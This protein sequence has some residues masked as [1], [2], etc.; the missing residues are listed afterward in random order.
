MQ[1]EKRVYPQTAMAASMNSRALEKATRSKT[2]S[3]SVISLSH[4]S[5]ITWAIPNKTIWS[6]DVSLKAPVN[7]LPH[8]MSPA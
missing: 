7:H 6:I 1:G 2:I 4:I 5:G 3:K 8:K